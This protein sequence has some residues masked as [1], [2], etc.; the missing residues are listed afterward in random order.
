MVSH[1]KSFI[2]NEF[3]KE[4]KL[5]YTSIF[6]WLLFLITSFILSSSYE[7]KYEWLWKINPGTWGDSFWGINSLISLITFFLVFKTF[8]LQGAMLESQKIELDLSKKAIQE[9]ND[10]SK[11][12][13]FEQTL[14]NA[15][16]SLDRL[17]LDFQIYNWSIFIWWREWVRAL[18]NNDFYINIDNCLSIWL[19][20]KKLT[21]ER[22][23]ELLRI[24]SDSAVILGMYIKTFHLLL[25]LIE[26]K[27]IKKEDANY[28]FTI[29][30]SHLWNPE[31][32][33]LY[34][35]QQNVKPELQWIYKKYFDCIYKK[36]ANT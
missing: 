13:I 29:V 5:I 1:V 18:L 33:L 11:I 17:I 15:I 6:V 10:L 16:Q 36:D 23:S 27:I 19:S 12:S 24:N 2:K 25:G 35:Q 21:K 34:L 31:Q 28:Y 4:E 26:K 3:P 30:N 9:Q 7:S 14:Y 22:L 20:G 32:W 8:R